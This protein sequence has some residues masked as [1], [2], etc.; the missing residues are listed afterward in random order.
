MCC[1]VHTIP[2]NEAMMIMKEKEISH[3]RLA[4]IAITGMFFQEVITGHVWPLI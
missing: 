3:C 1:L 4:M 2:P